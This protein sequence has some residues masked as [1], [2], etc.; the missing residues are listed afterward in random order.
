GDVAGGGEGSDLAAVADQVM[1]LAAEEHL[2]AKKFCDVAA[3][4]SGNDAVFQGGRHVG[5][6][7]HADAA[8]T[9]TA[10]KGGVSG[11]RARID[12]EGAGVEDSTAE[13][14]AGVVADRTVAERHCPAV[15]EAAAA[16][17]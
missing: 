15:V 2:V 9:A 8:T 6:G 10:K 16:R 4:I 7:Q 1:P 14:R 5:L 17:D 13:E 11:N 12:I 3:G